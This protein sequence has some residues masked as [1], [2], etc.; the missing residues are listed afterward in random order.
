MSAYQSAQAGRI[1]SDTGHNV[2]VDRWTQR[3]LQRLNTE[4]GFRKQREAV[5][6]PIGQSESLQDEAAYTSTNTISE[7]QRSQ[8]QVSSQVRSQPHHLA[9]QGERTV[10]ASTANA[11]QAQS[12]NTSSRPTNYSRQE[13][14]PSHSQHQH[15]HHQQQ[16]A[17]PTSPQSQ[18]SSDETYRPALTQS[19]SYNQQLDPQTEDTSM[20]FAG[21]GNGSLGSKQ[22]RTL[23]QNRQSLHQGISSRD[24]SGQ[25]ISSQGVPAFSTTILPTVNVGQPYQSGIAQQHPDVDRKTPQPMQTS[26]DMSPDEINQ[27]IKEHKELRKLSSS[28]FQNC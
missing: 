26:E 20:S 11:G 8:S 28:P 10:L 17:A 23:V 6:E 25:A 2:N 18:Y 14:Y 16:Y 21:N 12:F 1:S 27:L 7:P 4:Q 9:Y 15:Q 22:A 19:R 24:G 5:Q 3:Q 13:S